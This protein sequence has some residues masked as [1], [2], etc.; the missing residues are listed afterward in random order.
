MTTQELT[1]DSREVAEM[2]GR[3]H[4][5]LLR[6]IKNYVEILE[7]EDSAKLRAPEFFIPSTYLTAQNKEQPCFLITKKGCDMIANKLTGRKGIL[8]TATYVTRFEEMQ[9]ALQKQFNPYAATRQT[10]GDVA[11]FLHEVRLISKEGGISLAKS[12]QSATEYLQ[13][14]GEPLSDCLAKM[15]LE[16]ENAQ[17]ERQL[18]LFDAVDAGTV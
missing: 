11:R 16:K 2:I 7:E 12:M 1:L 14:K 13:A 6:T 8:F 4:K 3:E 18:T 17:Q 5:E 15:L 10:I 9:E